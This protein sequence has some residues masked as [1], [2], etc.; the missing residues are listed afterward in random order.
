MIEHPII[1]S[2]DMVRAILAGQKTQTRR[3]VRPQWPNDSIIEEMSATT[4]EGWQTIG[5]SGRWWDAGCCSYQRHCPY[6]VPGDHLWVRE[7]WKLVNWQWEDPEQKIMYSDG[8]TK[9]V[10]PD[11]RYIEEQPF[12]AWLMR[13]Y[14]RVTKHPV[15]HAVLDP[16][17]EDDT[18]WE[19]DEQ[20]LPWRPSIFMP[21]W[22]SRIV[23]EITGIRVERVQEIN[24]QDARAE[25]VKGGKWGDPG[26]DW[27]STSGV[28]WI[29][30][31]R[32][33]WDAINAKRGY[34]WDVNPWV[35]VIEFKRIEQGA[36]A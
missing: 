32:R 9:W 36:K 22:A 13:E 15:A 6:G 24:Q 3:V 29:V 5:H 23:L 26:V 11:L 25:G 35:W 19:V 8:S 30:P 21:R 20:A 34:G 4:P 14:E 2:T 12:D 18:R 27:V 10:N 28:D 7:N 31:F 17:Y 33:A 1:F 16:R